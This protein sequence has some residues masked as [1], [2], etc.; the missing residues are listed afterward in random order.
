MQIIQAECGETIYKFLN[1]IREYATNEGRILRARHNDI[2]I[3]V[4]PN[5]LWLDVA[6]KFDMQTKINRLQQG[7]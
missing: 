2:E 7:A 6:D 4:Y 3:T 1:R 5:S